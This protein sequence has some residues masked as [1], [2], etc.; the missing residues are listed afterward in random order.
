MGDGSSSAETLA[1]LDRVSHT[2]AMKPH[3][4]EHFKK[5]LRSG[6][7]SPEGLAQELLEFGHPLVTAVQANCLLELLR[8]SGQADYRYYHVLCSR[9]IDPWN[10][11]PHD[12]GIGHCYYG[13]MNT[14]DPQSRQGLQRLVGTSD[15]ETLA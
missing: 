12:H 8:G 13:Y 2:L 15:Q 11:S 9:V 14:T 4:F 6:Q 1:S 10:L 5:S 3:I 7:T